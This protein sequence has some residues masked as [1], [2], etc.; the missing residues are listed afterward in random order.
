MFLLTNLSDNL[1]NENKFLR[2][3]VNQ[4]NQ[5]LLKLSDNIN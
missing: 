5:E 2:E 1:I 4:K 3:N